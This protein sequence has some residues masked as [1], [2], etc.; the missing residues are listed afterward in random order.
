MRQEYTFDELQNLSS[1]CRKKAAVLKC[2]KKRCTGKVS[3]TKG[4]MPIHELKDSL[5]VK[6]FECKECKATGSMI[7]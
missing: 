4:R 1:Q 2:P 3:F 6:S 5:P 7:C